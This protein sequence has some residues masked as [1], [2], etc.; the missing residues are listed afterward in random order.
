[1]KDQ[2]T[3]QHLNCVIIIARDKLFMFTPSAIPL[4][5]TFWIWFTIMFEKKKKEKASSE[6]MH[7]KMKE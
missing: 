3:I 4:D 2:D 1:M 5:T 6:E 7:K